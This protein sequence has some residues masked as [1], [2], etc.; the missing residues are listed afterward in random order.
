MRPTRLMCQVDVMAKTLRVRGLPDEL[1]AVL[2]A[3]AAAAY[4]SLSD[5]VR[6]LLIPLA[7]QPT[8]KEIAARVA[9]YGEGAQSGDSVRLLRET[10]DVGDR[11]Q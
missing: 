1:R 7:N 10:R 4:M 6:S 5:Y 8:W 9:D 3:R 2:V 11:S